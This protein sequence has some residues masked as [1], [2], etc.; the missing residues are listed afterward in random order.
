MQI[1]RY[2]KFRCNSLDDGAETRRHTEPMHPLRLVIHQ[3]W[4]QMDVNERVRRRA[5]AGGLVLTPPFVGGSA[6]L[7][8]KTAEHRGAGLRAI[9]R[10]DERRYPDEF[11]SIG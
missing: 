3:Q 7:L 2:P 11:R 8:L 4:F 6:R 9:F 5:S 10:G 1:A